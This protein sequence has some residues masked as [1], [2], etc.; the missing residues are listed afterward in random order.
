MPPDHGRSRRDDDWPPGAPAPGGLR[1]SRVVVPA[2]SADIRQLFAI[3]NRRRRLIGATTIGALALAGAYLTL[4]AS[5]SYTATVSVLID[6]RT[7]PPIGTEQSAVTFGTPDATLIESQVKLIASDSVLRRVVQTEKLAE[8]PDFGVSRPGPRARLMAMLGLGPSTPVADE[9][10]ARASLALARAVTVKRSERTY[11]I[12]VDVSLGNAA[13]AAR[14]ANLV[15]EAYIADQREARGNVAREDTKWLNQRLVELQTRLQEAE[16]KA[17]DFKVRNR[18]TDAVGKNVR[19]QELADLTNELGR[20][21]ARTIEARAKHDQVSRL[22]AAGRPPEGTIDA[23]KS[24]VLEKLRTQYSEI[25]RQE[26]HYRTT[27]GERH[28]AMLEVQ[29]QLRESRQL[30]AA[31]LRRIA[32]SAANEYQQARAAELATERRAEAARQSTDTKNGDLV[33]LRELERDVDAHRIAY[34]KFLRARETMVDDTNDGLLGRIIAPATTPTS[35]SSPKTAAILF[36]ALFSGLSLG[37]GLALLQD[38][39]ATWSPAAGGSPD[40]AGPASPRP[41]SRGGTGL[42]TLASIPRVGA[43]AGATARLRAWMWSKRGAEAAK[44]DSGEAPLSEV[45]LRPKSEFSARIGALYAALASPEKVAPGAPPATILVTSAS[46]GCGKTVIAVNL[47]RAAAMAGRRVL[48]IDANAHNPSLSQLIEAGSEPS[49]IE[50]DGDNRPIYTVTDM[51]K[52]TLRFVPMLDAEERVRTRLERQ[53]S[54]ERINGIN[55]NFDFVVLDGATLEAG[56]DLRFIAGAVD[57]VVFVVGAGETAPDA[58]ALADWLDVPRDK[59]AGSVD[60]AVEAR[61]AA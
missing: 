15:A 37:I 44:A 31:E 12:D 61:Q 35:P 39:L 19:E 34:E 1:D 59:L 49:L 55:G 53:K 11:V 27:L 47:A 43:T 33:R 22:A 5:T 41:F 51:P 13:R 54:V 50:L 8:D 32:D 58:D 29:S 46:E 20:A 9:R 42:V 30:I 38:Y 24:P 36:I 18:I 28:P 60:S 45:S 4:V 6:S 26:S 14:L 52:A 2:E 48:L 23:L 10:V 21:R 57:R 3:L 40:P 25:A 7:R 17:Q 16:N 56:D